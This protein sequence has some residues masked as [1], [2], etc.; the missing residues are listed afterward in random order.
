MSFDTY[1]RHTIF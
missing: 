1:L